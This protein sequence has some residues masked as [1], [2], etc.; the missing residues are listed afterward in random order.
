MKR[1]A[2]LRQFIGGGFES[3]G[4]FAEPTRL[5]FVPAGAE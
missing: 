1:H 3:G 5:F 4:L 2:D